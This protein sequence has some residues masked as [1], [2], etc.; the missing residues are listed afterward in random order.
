MYHVSHALCSPRARATL[1]R[2]EDEAAVGGVLGKGS[3][4]NRVVAVGQWKGTPPLTGPDDY[5]VPRDVKRG[6]PFTRKWASELAGRAFTRAGVKAGTHSMRHTFVTEVLESSVP[7]HVAQRMAGHSSVQTA[8][9]HYAHVRD[10]AL[11]EAA[12]DL[13][14]KRQRER[15]PRR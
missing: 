15:S 12:Q 2:W 4:E 1:R 11:K 6:T 5:V 10:T 7:I 3:L 9:N 14:R 13:A 8:L